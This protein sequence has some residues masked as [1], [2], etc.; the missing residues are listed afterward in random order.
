MD[1]RVHL[2]VISDDAPAETPA[3]HEP[4]RARR[5]RPRGQRPTTVS[6]DRLPKRA[7]EEGRALYPE[8]VEG[9]PQ[10]RAE[11]EGGAR[12]CPYV[13]C[14][15]HLYLDVSE[16]TGAIKMNFP[17]LEVW[18]LAESCALDV[19]DRGGATLD[20]IAGHMNL[21]RERVRQVELRALMLARGSIASAD[22]AL[23]GFRAV[24]FV[25]APEREVYRGLARGAR[26][27]DDGDEVVVRE[28]VAAE[29]RDMAARVR[30]AWGSGVDSVPWRVPMFGSR[31]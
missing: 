1:G 23:R 30:Q 24:V 28:A 29:D 9:R 8:A 4:V 15:H 3:R 22:D 17:D 21:T 6:M 12:P 11:C 10:T 27:A 25:D 18:E 31:G 7:L 16:Q 26:D 19:A 2:P 5:A 13:S 14:V 20:E